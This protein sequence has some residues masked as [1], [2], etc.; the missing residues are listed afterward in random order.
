MQEALEWL[1]Y[2]LSVV[3]FCLP[4]LSFYVYSCRSLTLLVSFMLCLPVVFLSAGSIRR[5]A[6]GGWRDRR[7]A[8]EALQLLSTEGD[9]KCQKGKIHP[10]WYR[11]TDHKRIS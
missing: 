10:F 3:A 8:A 1:V 7:Q 2:C 9:Q 4:I 5:G 6:P 11:R